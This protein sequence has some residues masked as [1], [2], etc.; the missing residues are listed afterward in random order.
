MNIRDLVN[1]SEKDTVVRQLSESISLQ[2]LI[3]DLAMDSLKRAFKGYID[4]KIKKDGSTYSVKGYT[5]SD[6]EMSAA[7]VFT[8][9]G[10]SAPSINGVV[11]IPDRKDNNISLGGSWQK[12]KDSESIAK[13]IKSKLG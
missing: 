5:K 1:Q 11:S 12:F 9:F 13:M 10:N 6:L 4:V 7:F 8:L 3:D 2:K